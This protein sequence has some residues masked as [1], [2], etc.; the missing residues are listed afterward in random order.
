[1]DFE[2]EIAKILL[3]KKGNKELAIFYDDSGWTLAIGNPSRH[4]NLGEVSG[5]Y[6]VY[7]D[8][9]EAIIQEMKKLMLNSA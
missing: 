3:R 4:A 7:G 1:M 6:Q 2:A 9:L 5:E 8:T